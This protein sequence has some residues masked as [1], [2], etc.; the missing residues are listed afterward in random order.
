MADSLLRPASECS[1]RPRPMAAARA[2]SEREPRWRSLE[3]DPP[4]LRPPV[5]APS[6]CEDDEEPEEDAI[7]TERM[8][9]PVSVPL[10]TPV[11]R[12]RRQRGFTIR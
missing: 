12:G 6:A 5:L 11:F 2:A 8:P 3:A 7:P 9:V 4:A 1:L 10:D